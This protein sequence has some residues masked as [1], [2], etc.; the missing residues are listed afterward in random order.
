MEFSANLY[1]PVLQNIMTVTRATLSPRQ[2][3]ETSSGK[4]EG[5]VTRG[6][7]AAHRLRRVDAFLARY[8]PGLLRRRDGEYAR[9]YF[10]DLGYGAMPATTLESAQRLRRFN[11]DL[12][13]LGVEIEAER[14][15]AART[16]A[17]SITRFRLG[18]FNLPLKR[19][20]DGTPERVRM[21]RAFNVLRQYEEAA[22]ADAYARMAPGVLPGGLLI[23]G[24]S[25]P[26][27]R[28]WVANVLRRTAS[29]HPDDAWKP[30]ALVFSTNFKSDFSPAQ[31]Q[32]V[33]PKNF[34]HRVVPG[35]PIY[36]FFEVWVQAVQQ[37][38]AMR[39]WGVRQWFAA[40]AQRLAT[41]G[42]YRINL[43]RSW[44]RKGWLIW[45]QD[46]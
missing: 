39:V 9:A 5:E 18:G 1:M 12:P 21:I 43:S 3:P 22:V 16:Y 31:F 29:A 36:T 13:V 42:G 15:A 11:A 23:E 2:H 32:A 33:L 34:I 41:D 8:D 37:T 19:W 30:E 4:P 38:R 24:T 28:I 6:K 46:A 14:V 20:P 40:A 17:D 27:G 45:Q 35:E 44:L 26:F 10:I 7:T 25:D